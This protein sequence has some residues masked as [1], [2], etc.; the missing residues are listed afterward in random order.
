M[1]ICNA[2]DFE[3]PWVPS[4]KLVKLLCLGGE[5]HMLVNI[6]YEADKQNCNCYLILGYYIMSN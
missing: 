5:L 2:K 4:A 3:E 6:S 1:R